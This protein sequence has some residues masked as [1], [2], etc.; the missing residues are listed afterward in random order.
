M[1]NNTISAQRLRLKLDL[2]GAAGGKVQGTQADPVLWQGFD[3]VLEIASFLG[4]EVQDISNLAAVYLELKPDVASA[5]LVTKTLLAA[6][7]GTDLDLASWNDQTKQHARFELSGAELNQTIA[8]P[9]AGL[10]LYCIVYAVTK[11][12]PSKNVAIGW[13]KAT[14]KSFGAQ[15]AGTP[16]DPVPL[17][18]TAAQVAAA[19]DAKLLLPPGVTS[20]RFNLDGTF[21]LLEIS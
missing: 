15:I 21:D 18:V 10:Q 1:S 11:D 20:L 16:P 6:Q 2:S 12:S 17:A 13:F 3:A 9:T 5:A 19:L 14:L 4:A 7:L 8:D